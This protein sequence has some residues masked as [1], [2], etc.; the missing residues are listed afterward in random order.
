M[1]LIRSIHTDSNSQ[2]LLFCQTAIHA[3]NTEPWPCVSQVRECRGGG[4][5]HTES[6]CVA[7]FKSNANHNLS[8]KDEPLL[9]SHYL[10][11][12]LTF[13]PPPPTGNRCITI[14]T[15]PPTTGRSQGHCLTLSGLP[16]D[17]TFWGR[18]Q[19]PVE[20]VRLLSGQHPHTL[21][22]LLWVEAGS[23]GCHIL[24]EPSCSP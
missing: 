8:V 23:S 2:R 12:P 16:A 5:Q 9:P 4:S 15:A 6:F 24:P 18:W 13:T 3:M 17:V 19:P 21:L 22:L 14:V 7:R 1:Y 20:R 10:Q 11:R